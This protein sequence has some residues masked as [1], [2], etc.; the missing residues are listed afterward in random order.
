MSRWLRYWHQGKRYYDLRHGNADMVAPFEDEVLE[1]VSR[2]QER[3]A[4]PDLE[5]DEPIT[6]YAEV[7][8]ALQEREEP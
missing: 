6:S 1:R 2:E 8:R 3:R 7:L 5:P 4:A